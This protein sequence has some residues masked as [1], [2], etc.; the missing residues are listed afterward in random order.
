MVPFSQPFHTAAKLVILRSSS[1]TYDFTPQKLSW[2]LMACLIKKNCL[3]LTLST[4]H[5]MVGC[6]LP[7]CLPLLLYV[8]SIFELKWITQYSI[9]PKRSGGLPLSFSSSWIFC[10]KCS[11]QLY[12]STSL[13]VNRYPSFKVLLNYNLLDKAFL[14]SHCQVHIISRS[15]KSLTHGLYFSN[16]FSLFYPVSQ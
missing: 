8:F 6:T 14:G 9:S 2:L 13:F 10:L 12:A 4:H 1:C 16:E 15:I 3:I 7:F 5:T 11:T